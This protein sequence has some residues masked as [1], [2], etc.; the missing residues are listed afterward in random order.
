M[1]RGARRW[2]RHAVHA[3]PE[4]GGQLGGQQLGGGVVGGQVREDE[5]D[6]HRDALV[7]R[8]G[9]PDGQFGGVVERGGGVAL[10]AGGHDVAELH[11]VVG[12]PVVHPHRQGPRGQHLLGDV[13]A[14]AE[15]EA[16]AQRLVPQHEFAEHVEHVADLHQ[17]RHGQ[18]LGE[19]E[20]RLEL[21]QPPVDAVPGALLSPRRGAGARPPAVELDLRGALGDHDGT[22]SGVRSNR[23]RRR[24]STV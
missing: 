18:P 10:P 12:G 13:A 17:Q 14:G 4:Q 6:E 1:Q 20:E 8:D 21:G 24:H 9:Q 3:G 16:R 11:R 7:Q 23:T 22:T 2:R 15:V 19:E 5:H